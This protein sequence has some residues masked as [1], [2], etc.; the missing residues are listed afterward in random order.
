MLICAFS[1]CIKKKFTILDFIYTYY[2]YISIDI[3]HTN[4]LKKKTHT[5]LILNDC[6][7]SIIFFSWEIIP[8]IITIY[9]WRKYRKNKSKQVSMAYVLLK[10]KKK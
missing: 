7:F 8:K 9:N 5:H 3:T 4:F 6:I 10:K 2:I 1:I